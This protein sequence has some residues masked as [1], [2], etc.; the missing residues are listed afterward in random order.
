MATIPVEISVAGYEKREVL[1]ISYSFSQ[2]FDGS[3]KTT[4]KPKGGT[5][6]VS[7]K[8]INNAKGKDEILAWMLATEESALKDGSI[9]FKDTSAGGADMREVVFKKGSCVNYT[10]EWEEAK[11]DKNGALLPPTH[12][13]KIVIACKTI[14][15]NDVPPLENVW[16]G[17]TPDSAATKAKKEDYNKAVKIT[18]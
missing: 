18:W 17:D 16:E 5:I 9:L 1:A 6:N 15:I 11:L 10:L 3:C 7:M 14:Q 4:G 2:A 13:E 12:T 8:A